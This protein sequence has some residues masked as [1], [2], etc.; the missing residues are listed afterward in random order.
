M[1]VLNLQTGWR[2]RDVKAL[3]IL[4]TVATRVVPKQFWLERMKNRISKWQC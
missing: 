4:C 2:E 1:I 3:K